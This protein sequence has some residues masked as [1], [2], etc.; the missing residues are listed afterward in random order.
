MTFH[1]PISNGSAAR[2]S[3]LSLASSGGSPV[4]W[5]GRLQILLVRRNSPKSG[6]SLPQAKPQP[7]CS[8]IVRMLFVHDY[9]VTNGYF[10]Q[11]SV[12]GEKIHR[13]YTRVDIGLSCRE[14]MG[15]G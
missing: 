4:P 3:A 15:F 11:E 10:D 9:L 14:I 2:P 5:R 6:H 12:Q 1:S 13:R 7:Y 8:R